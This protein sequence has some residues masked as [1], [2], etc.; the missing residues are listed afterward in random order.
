M[1]KYQPTSPKMLNIPKS[2]GVWLIEL[3]NRNRAQ[4]GY[5]ATILKEWEG[6]VWCPTV[7]HSNF[8]ARRNG[9]VYITGNTPIQGTASD[10]TQTSMANLQKVFSKMNLTSLVIGTVHDSI[11]FD[12]HPSEIA[13]V[14]KIIKTVMEN[15]PYDF[16]KNPDGSY[17]VPYKCDI[18]IGLSYGATK[19][20]VEKDGAMFV[21]K[22]VKEVGEDGT[23]VT[24]KVQVPFEEY[25]FKEAA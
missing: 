10:L 12:V 11:M 24:K 4:S 17:I 5:G 14:Y 21:V 22:K 18:G 15:P 9:M 7:K 25:Q 2:D 6:V 20:L 23:E 1:K 3:R 19:D 8:V 13:I 16:C